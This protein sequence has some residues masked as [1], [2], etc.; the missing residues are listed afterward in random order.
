MTRPCLAFDKLF[1]FFTTLEQARVSQQAF[2]FE[3]AQVWLTID[4]NVLNLRE[5]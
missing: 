5:G 4:E 1:S 3:L 2:I